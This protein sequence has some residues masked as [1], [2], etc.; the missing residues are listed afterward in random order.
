MKTKM[1]ALCLVGF[2]M[3]ACSSSNTKATPEQ[4]QALDEL[5]ASQSFMIESEWAVPQTSSSLIALQNSGI[6][7]PGD[8]A[9][10]VSLIGNPNFLKLKGDAIDS[11]LPYFGERQMVNRRNDNG[12]IEFEDTIKNIE[13]EQHKNSSYTIKFDAKSHNENYNV[14]IRLYPNLRSEMLLKGAKRFPIRYTGYVSKI[15]E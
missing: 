6:L 7:A 2:F 5:V 3:L 14:I 11:K 10:R 15:P 8:N 9:G 13:I 1:I 4:I 12:S